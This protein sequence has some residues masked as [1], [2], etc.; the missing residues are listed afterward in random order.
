MK[1][2]YCGTLIVKSK[3]KSLRKPNLY[4]LEE[5]FKFKDYHWTV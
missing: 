5:Y 1:C 3:L 2:P 4:K